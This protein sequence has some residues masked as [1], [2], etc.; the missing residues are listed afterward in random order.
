NLKSY[1]GV[2][3]KDVSIS[4]LPK[5]SARLYLPNSI[6]QDKKLPILVYFHGGA[7]CIESAFSSSHLRYLNSLSAEAHALVVSVEYRLAP[8]HPL[9]A[10]YDDSWA[11]LLWVASH[12]SAEVSI[13]M[14]KN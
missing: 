10:A 6:P 13:P 9:P 3:S 12:R 11:A 4:D 2:F 5:V 14:H 7:F 8:E 1:I